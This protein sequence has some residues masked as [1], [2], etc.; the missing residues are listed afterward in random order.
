[1][2]IEDE[3]VLTSTEFQGSENWL[4]GYNCAAKG[5][6]YNDNISIYLVKRAN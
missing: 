4:M 1:M 6:S 3:L 2:E 5:S